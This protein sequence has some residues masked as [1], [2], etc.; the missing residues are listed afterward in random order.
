MTPLDS[1]QNNLKKYGLITAFV[2]EL[3]ACVV[4]GYLIG[5]FIDGKLGSDPWG[6][7]TGVIVGF[8]GGMFRFYFQTKRFMS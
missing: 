5:N 6:L 1:Q 7:M 4:L 8:I 2:F 3:I